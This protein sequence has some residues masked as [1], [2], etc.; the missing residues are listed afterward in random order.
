[1]SNNANVDI[2]IGRVA[3]TLDRLEVTRLLTESNTVSGH[4]AVLVAAIYP[5]EGKNNILDLLL[6]HVIGG[7]QL[8]APPSSEERSCLSELCCP[9]R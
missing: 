5:E 8:S 1:M 9:G 3:G 7:S 4:V 6:L 2:T